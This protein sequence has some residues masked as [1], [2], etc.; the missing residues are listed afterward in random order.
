[1]IT[2]YSTTHIYFRRLELFTNVENLTEQGLLE[3]VKKDRNAVW[4]VMP[5]GYSVFK[6]KFIEGCTNI[7][8]FLVEGFYSTELCGEHVDYRIIEDANFMKT[9]ENM[10]KNKQ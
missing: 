10:L 7:D 5:H 3:L 6:R 1:M 9:R 4:F 8:G 2:I